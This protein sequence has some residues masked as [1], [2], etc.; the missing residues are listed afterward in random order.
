MRGQFQGSKKILA[1]FP[2]IYLLRPDKPIHA[3]TD[4]AAGQFIA[5]TLWQYDDSFK[6]LVPI[7]H[8]SHKLSASEKNFSQWEVEGLALVYCLSKEEAL[9][10]FGNMTFHTDARGLTFINKY[11]N[12]SSKLS[13]WDLLIRSFNMTIHFLPNTNALIR[14]TD[15]FTRNSVHGG[16]KN[17][18]IGNLQLQDF[19]NFDFNGLPDLGISDAMALITQLQSCFANCPLPCENIKKIKTD[20]LCPPTL[21]S[22]VT[23]C[24]EVLRMEGGGLIAKVITCTDPLNYE[25]SVLS[26]F[27]PTQAF[28]ASTIDWGLDIEQPMRVKDILKNYLGQVDI[29]QLVLAQKQDSWISKLETGKNKAYFKLDEI[30]MTK[31]QLENGIWVSQIILPAALAYELIHIYHQRLFVKHESVLKMRRHLE[32]LFYIRNYAKIAQKI[33]SNCKFC[34]YNKSYP[35]KK[36]DPGIR[37]M[38]EAPRQ[39]IYID[40]CTVRSESDTDSFLTILDA[41]SKFVVYIPVNKD[42]PATTIID[43][44]F[45][46]WVSYFNF[47]IGIC[48]DGGKNVCNALIGEI[49]AKMNT[50]LVRISPANSQAN[51]SERYNLLCIQTLRIF[52]QNYSITDNNFDKILSLC[53]Q[54]I[55]QSIQ[56]N[57]YSA[58]YL[59]YGTKPR[60]N[61]FLTFQKL[62][63]MGHLETHVQDLVKC[64]NI[65]FIL[66]QQMDTDKNIEK[67]QLPAKY[68]VGDFVFL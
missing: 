37:I 34:A 19:M 20:F 24:P 56:K 67:E 40:I 33:I 8:N 66:S 42:C 14:V 30:I 43:L 25:E 2:I 68:R 39:F 31:K 6:L 60:K 49:A 38:V 51:L 58:F 18:K 44:L 45:H 47:P 15:I 4:G 22:R 13:R 12:A 36:L 23:S 48:T 11:A 35:N 61:M 7:K 63:S 57:G 64:Q 62:S 52:E 16:Q 65:C 17:K 32:T 54:M 10:S 3:T 9:L 53:G 28:S 26:S 46:N 50:K 21:T 27:P 5:Y 1:M 41:F 29:H 59:H 55:N